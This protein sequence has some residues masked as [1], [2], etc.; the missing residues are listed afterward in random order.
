[1]MNDQEG[2][3]GRI[4]DSPGMD[5]PEETAEV[6]WKDKFLRAKADFQNLQRR[7]V[8]EQRA[9]VRYANA[10]FA[11]ALLDPVD[12][13]ERT[14]EARPPGENEDP[15]LAGIRLIHGKL[16][17]LLKDHRVEVIEA[18]GQHFDPRLHEALLQQPCRDL[19]PGTVIQEV[20]KGYKLHDRVLRPARVIVAKAHEPEADEVESNGDD[21]R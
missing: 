8:E 20:Q 5:L 14:L 16:A 10:D 6:D 17:K 21:P 3:N 9:A 12:D 11:R 15:V 4:G 7:A 13:L 18:L 2:A 1:M 19:P